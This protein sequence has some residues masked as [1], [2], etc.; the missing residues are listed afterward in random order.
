MDN[1][2]PEDD[3]PSL[4]PYLDKP[5]RSGETVFPPDAKTED[6]HALDLFLFTIQREGLLAPACSLFE[7]VCPPAGTLLF[8]RS[9]AAQLRV[10][11]VD[12]YELPRPVVGAASALEQHA[13]MAEVIRHDGPREAEGYSQNFY[14]IDYRSWRV[15]CLAEG[16]PNF[17]CLAVCPLRAYFRIGNY[18]MDSTGDFL[19][20][21][22]RQRRV[23]S[24]APAFRLLQQRVLPS[25]GSPSGPSVQTTACHRGMNRAVA[26][27][28]RAVL[29][30][31]LQ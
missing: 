5:L 22:D 23:L 18:L 29:D 12:S 14:L 4:A 31:V 9:V 10:S 27:I 19:F 11:F 1:S 24:A 16:V 20:E 17:D 28:R 3:W 15:T 21:F 6:R 25:M 30:A 13:E 8:H 7:V 26:D 2:A